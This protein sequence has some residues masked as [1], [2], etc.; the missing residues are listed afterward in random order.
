MAVSKAENACLISCRVRGEPQ[1]PI[2]I[3]SFTHSV[4]HS[5]NIHPLTVD[6]QTPEY[7]DNNLATPKL[8]D[9]TQFSQTL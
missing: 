4:I 9:H 5:F 8:C 6:R 2:Y 1:F 7:L 3:H